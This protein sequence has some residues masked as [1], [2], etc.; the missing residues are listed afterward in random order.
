MAGIFN[1]SIFNNA[2]FNTGAVAVQERAVSGR[3]RPKIYLY[4]E[5]EEELIFKPPPPIP[6]RIKAKKYK[7]DIRTPKVEFSDFRQWEK[8]NPYI[9]IK[10]PVISV[11][12]IDEDEE[13]LLLH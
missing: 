10:I 8:L 4:E 12:D 3:R 2:V 1:A 7:V 6:V 5:E 13:W 9:E 11:Q